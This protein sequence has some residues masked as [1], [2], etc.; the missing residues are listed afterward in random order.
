MDG[1]NS[2]MADLRDHFVEC[3]GA[4][5]IVAFAP[6]RIN[7]IGEHTDYN[8]GL[9]FPAAIDLGIAAAV[10]QNN[11]NRIRVWA[12][13]LDETF[14][15]SADQILVPLA[16][17]GWRNYIIGVVAQAQRQG[18]SFSGFDLMFGGSIPL[19]S[20]LSSSA[21]L[22]NSVLLALNQL[23]DW[24]FSRLSLLQMAQAAENSFVGVLCGI[25]DQYASMLGKEQQAFVLDCQQLKAD[26]VSAALEG[27]EWMLINSQVK[28]QHAE[29][30]YNSR[31]QSCESAREKLGV[32]SLSDMSLLALEEKR[33]LL[34]PNEYTKARYVVEENHRVQQAYKA[35]QAQNTEALGQL[36]FQSHTGLRDQYEVSCPEIDFLVDL[37]A[38]SPAVIGAR[39]MGGGFGGCTL[40]LIDQNKREEIQDILAAYS[41]RFGIQAELIPVRIAAGA[42]IIFQ[43]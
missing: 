41:Q 21:A 13:D 20:G 16:E 12:L 35:L 7:I 9:V 14:E 11:S 43:P 18:K 17:G 22:E 27:Y 8:G 3:Y 24:E 31:R 30:G 2:W 37:A 26:Y 36:L 39:I 15:F 38:A 19:G 23:F 25:M 10:A 1:Y 4:A 42:R 32:Q 40:N 28:H 33:V 29:S 34:T 5:P 6:G